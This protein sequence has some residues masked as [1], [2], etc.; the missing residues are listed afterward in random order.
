M[1]EVTSEKQPWDSQAIR[2]VGGERSTAQPM[3]LRNPA[4][5]HLRCSLPLGMKTISFYYTHSF[6][7]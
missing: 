3:K 7:F 2:S 6:S 5:K 4:L 1:N